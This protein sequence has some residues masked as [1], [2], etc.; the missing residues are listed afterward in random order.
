M[1]KL[2]LRET[3]IHISG[4]NRPDLSRALHVRGMRCSSAFDAQIDLAPINTGGITK[5]NVI[6]ADPRLAPVR[7][8]T[9]GLPAGADTGELTTQASVDLQEL[10]N[11]S[12]E[13]SIDL[14][15]RPYWTA[16]IALAEQVGWDPVDF[17]HAG[18]KALEGGLLA[19]LHREKRD[20]T[21]RRIAVVDGVV[22]TSRI[23]LTLRILDSRS[24]DELARSSKREFGDYWTLKDA[25]HTIK[26][27]DERVEVIARPRSLAAGRP[28]VLTV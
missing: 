25:V 18:H 15:F 21:R 10:V 2:T 13:D 5:I 7:P 11:V 4:V 28:W 23:E 24:G 1:V 20:R 16:M 9:G 17:E 14:L 27:T 19:R 26:W 8:W 3:A 22:E 6:L 12:A